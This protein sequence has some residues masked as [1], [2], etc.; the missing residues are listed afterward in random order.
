MPAHTI[1]VLVDDEYRDQ[2]SADA[3]GEIAAAALAHQQV[4]PPCEMAVV[5]TGDRALQELNRRHRG[6]DTP[7]DV[8]AFPNAPHSSF[9]EAPEQPRHL[10]DIVISYPQASAQ[11]RALAHGVSAELQLLVVHGVLHLLGHDD[12]L[13][14][15]RARMWTAQGEIIAAQAVD[16]T[17]PE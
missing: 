1:E 5:V 14:S 7:T 11:A 15:K 6:M 12:T 3:L 17:L 4:E 2:V 8:L 9:V 13:E 16:V 10:G